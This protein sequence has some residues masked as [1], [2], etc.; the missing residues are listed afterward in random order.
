MQWLPLEETRLQVRFSGFL[1][2]VVSVFVWILSRLSGFPA[3]SKHMQIRQSGN[4][5]LSIGAS[6]A[7]LQN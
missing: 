6:A 1:C 5:K 3:Q 2:I 7:S 4:S